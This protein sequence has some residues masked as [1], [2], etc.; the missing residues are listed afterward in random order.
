ML[1]EQFRV[2]VTG[3]RYV[4]SRFSPLRA[5]TPSKFKMCY[6]PVYPRTISICP[7]QISKRYCFSNNEVITGFRNICDCS[8]A[9]YCNRE[10]ILFTSS[11]LSL[12]ISVHYCYLLEF[13]VGISPIF[14]GRLVAYDNMPFHVRCP[15]K[16]AAL[17]V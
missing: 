2:F 13:G 11:V 7:Y 6:L 5:Q 15:W 8:I 17:K 1:L 3:H 10:N 16:T 4:C 14:C 9:I 12:Y